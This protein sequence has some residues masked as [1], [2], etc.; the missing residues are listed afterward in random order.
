MG[1]REAFEEYIRLNFLRGKKDDFYA[2]YNNHTE[3]HFTHVQQ[4]AGIINFSLTR[5]NSIY[6]SLRLT[7]EP[8]CKQQHAAILNGA[9]AG[10][11][12]AGCLLP[13]CIQFSAADWT[14]LDI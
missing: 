11:H 14:H 10:E 2:R 5:D 3:I 9:F 7:H 1:H 4:G 6:R 12:S 8:T 13:S